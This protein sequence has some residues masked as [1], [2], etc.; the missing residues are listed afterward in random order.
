MLP[1]YVWQ[2]VN[3]NHNILLVITLN[4]SIIAAIELLTAALDG[5]DSFDSSFFNEK[6]YS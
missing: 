6:L 3:S 4:C 2:E 5:L 1:L